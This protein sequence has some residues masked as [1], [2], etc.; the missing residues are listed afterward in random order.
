MLCNDAQLVPPDAGDP[1]WR[2][3]GDPT[4]AALL[5]LALKAGVEPDQLR[6]VWPRRDEMPF[7]AACKMMA[8]RHGYGPGG[9]FVS[10]APRK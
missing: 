4:E 3:L 6:R 1:R 2:A 7:D 9:G 5:T 8:T 10:R